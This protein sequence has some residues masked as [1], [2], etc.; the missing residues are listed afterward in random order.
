MIPNIIVKTDALL[1][2]K[3]YCL[4]ANS[5]KTQHCDPSK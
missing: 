2:P 5:V 4:N 1:L 3:K